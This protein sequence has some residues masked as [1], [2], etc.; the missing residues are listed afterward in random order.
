M[1]TTLVCEREYAEKSWHTRSGHNTV[2]SGAYSNDMPR[3]Y[4]N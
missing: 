3:T 2:F 1:K 4:F